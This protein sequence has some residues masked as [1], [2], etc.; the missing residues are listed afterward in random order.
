MQ[1]TFLIACRFKV[2]DLGAKCYKDY[3][4]R[5]GIKDRIDMTLRSLKTYG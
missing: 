4:S 5:K 3:V 1:T 2:G